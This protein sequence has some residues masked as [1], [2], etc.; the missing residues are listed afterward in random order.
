MVS[1]KPVAVEFNRTTLPA[2][3]R[4]TYVTPTCE[5]AT[6]SGPPLNDTRNVLPCLALWSAVG[7]SGATEFV[8]A[9]AI[10]EPIAQLT[11]ERRVIAMGPSRRSRRES[12]N[13]RARE[14]HALVALGPGKA[15]RTKR[16]NAKVERNTRPSANQIDPA[17]LVGN[18]GAPAGR[19]ARVA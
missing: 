2:W 15:Y 12:R 16:H 17:Q 6:P 14:E 11:R 13:T 3:S 5:T 8:H 1:L 4:L 7:P 9:T 18:E 19:G 10:H